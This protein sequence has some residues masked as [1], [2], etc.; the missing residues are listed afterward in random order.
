M[1]TRRSRSL[2][3]SFVATALVCIA[4]LLYARAL[5]AEPATA[6]TDTEYQHVPV[7]LWLLPQVSTSGLANDRLYTNVALSLGASGYARLRG[8]DLSLGGS[9]ITE[10]MSGAQATV[11]L[12]Y[13]GRSAS[14]AQLSVGANIAPGYMAGLQATVGLNYV[15][16]S[17][18]GAQ[19]A[20]GANIAPGHATGLQASS[21]YN[22]A[23]SLRGVQLGLINFGG[24]VT[25][26]QVG[27]INI[28]G[29][30]RGTQI[31]LVN[32]S[33]DVDAPVGLI[34]LV[35]NGQQHLELW[36]S[37]SAPLNL[38]F[39]LG[40]RHVYTLLTAGYQPEGETDRWMVG[41]GLGGHIPLGQRFYIDADVVS[42]HV[43]DDE[44][45]TDELNMLNKLRV[46]GGYRLHDRF[47]VFA[48]AT[49]NVLATRVD[50]GSDFGL[51]TGRRL[52]S[53]SNETT[54]RIWPGFLAGLRI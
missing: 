43:N 32:L 26:S 24:E 18:S 31:G 35:K 39:K 37:D 47:A 48:G 6:A 49:F 23:G 40:S 15:G 46:V 8:L 21:G 42:W 50:D 20:V 3:W 27:L 16:L 22:H 45:W 34:S 53:E 29:K 38:G 19:L 17:A 52:T 44:A 2:C 1:F 25:G 9:W 12:T 14:G 5:R 4:T 7:S 10:E 36:G 33:E 11:G 54:V 30:V 41:L 51:I 13:A 28:G